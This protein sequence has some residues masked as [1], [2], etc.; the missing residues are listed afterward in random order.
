MQFLSIDN[1]LT[2][3]EAAVIGDN[4]ARQTLTVT[5]FFFNLIFKVPQKV[6]P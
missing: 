5:F 2:L 1:D 6:N 3:D 4:L